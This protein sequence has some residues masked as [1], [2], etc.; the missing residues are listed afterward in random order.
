[1]HTVFNV[2]AIHVI[3]ELIIENIPKRAFQHFGAGIKLEFF[4]VFM[5]HPFILLCK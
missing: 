1:V 4:N 3:P 2:K 5:F